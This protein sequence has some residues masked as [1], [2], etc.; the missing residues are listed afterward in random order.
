MN[1]GLTG[2]EQ[3]EGEWGEI[4]GWTIPLT[5]LDYTVGKFYYSYLAMFFHCFLRLSQKRLVI[6][7]L[8]I[9]HEFQMNY[10]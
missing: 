2:L 6:H 1:K 9:P 7:L 3:H 10:Y 5:M 4:L 8:R